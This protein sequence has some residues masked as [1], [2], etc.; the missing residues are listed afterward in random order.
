MNQNK[1]IKKTGTMTY[2]STIL[3]ALYNLSVKSTKSEY[4]FYDVMK[5]LKSYLGFVY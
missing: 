1:M 2:L 5:N 4:I 3:T